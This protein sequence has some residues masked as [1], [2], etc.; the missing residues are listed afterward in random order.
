MTRRFPS[1][2]PT[3]VLFALLAALLLLVG[4]WGAAVTTLVL[5]VALA[6]LVRAAQ[7]LE[8]LNTT[9]ASLANEARE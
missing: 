8:R 5:T 7:A 6:Q 3:Y 9:L 2:L 4:Q 1:W